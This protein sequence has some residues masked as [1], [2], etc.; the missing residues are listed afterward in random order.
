MSRNKSPGGAFSVSLLLNGEYSSLFRY[1]VILLGLVVP[2]MLLLV[3]QHFVALLLA[4]LF[5]LSGFFCY[6]ALIFKAAVFEPITHDLAG[7]FGLPRA[8]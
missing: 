4:T 3:S 6:R 7:S 1:M 8:S 5:M 2:M